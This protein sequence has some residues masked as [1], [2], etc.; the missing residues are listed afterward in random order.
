MFSKSA[1]PLEQLLQ[2]Q[3]VRDTGDITT[4]VCNIVVVSSPLDRGY[5]VNK[6]IG[7]PQCQR[8]SAWT[9]LKFLR[10]F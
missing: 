1:A 9:I 8:N 3:K 7:N 10:K 4:Q 6:A 2:P 5:N